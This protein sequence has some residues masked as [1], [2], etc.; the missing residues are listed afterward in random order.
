MESYRLVVPYR[1]RLSWADLGGCL[2]WITSHAVF[3][4]DWEMHLTVAMGDGF[5]LVVGISY[6][7]WAMFGR[8]HH[9]P[10]HWIAA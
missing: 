6:R 9:E 3:G 2:C 7:V 8:R 5:V 4:D 10:N 1:L